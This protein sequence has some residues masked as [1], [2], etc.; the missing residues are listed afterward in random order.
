M[1]VQELNDFT[2]K[3]RVNFITEI[4]ERLLAWESEEIKSSFTDCGR[5]LSPECNEEEKNIKE[6]SVEYIGKS[7]E[8][9]DKKK[10]KSCLK[11]AKEGRHH[12]KHL[13]ESGTGTCHNCNRVSSSSSTQTTL[14]SAASV[15]SQTKDASSSTAAE[16]S[17]ASA[18]AVTYNS[19]S[20]ETTS[21]SPG[22]NNGNCEV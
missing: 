7:V 3:E 18:D 9:T 17:S 19:G 1:K 2:E 5:N 10:I 11:P 22:E 6:N 15:S 12:K 13:K 16:S 20:T 4:R 8:K 21:S 14:M